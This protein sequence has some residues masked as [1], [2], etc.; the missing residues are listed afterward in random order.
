MKNL[1]D[2]GILNLSS[3]APMMVL[4]L[5]AV[6]ILV[7][8][9]IN[10][11]ISR[12]FWTMLAILGLAIN[13]FFLFGYSG[14]VRGFF[15]LVLID[16]FAFI[17][18]IIILLFSILFL[19]LTLSKE[20]FHDCSLAEFYA[21]YLFMIVGYEFMV[22][23]QNLIVILVGLETSS[24]ALYALIALHNRSRA[25]EAAIKYF[26]M[27][28]LSTGF[29][30][31]TIVLF[32][33]SSASL[34]INAISYSVKNTDPILI[35]AACIF[36]ICSIGFKLSLIPFHT[37]I[38]D[39]YEG[40]SEVMA[41]YISIVPKIAGFIVAMR[42]FESLYDSNIA[43]I[44]IS[45]YIIAVLTMTLANIMALIQNDVKRMLAF[46]SIS[47]AGFVL[48]AVVIGT[49]S[50]NIGLFLYW[51]MFSFANLGAFSVLWFTR[52]KQNIWHERFDH[53]FEKFNGL[54]KFLP[55]TSFLMALFM[56]SLAGIPPFS[57]FWGKMYLMGSAISS[58]FIFMAVIMAINSA[59][60]VYYYLRII[61]CMFLKE[62]LE[63]AEASLYK[64]NSSNAIKFIITLSAILCILAPFMV[65]FW[66]D[67]VLKFI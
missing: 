30:C 9:F 6:F 22:S 41:G 2:F 64:Q 28:A 34:D 25:I 63:N 57:V 44:Q 4:S 67:F 66:T 39:V 11:N 16:G 59:I 26:T 49:K 36:L 12:T 53:P 7:L 8:N 29:F 58:G 51:L 65:K 45:L 61:V 52:S 17:S 13:I 38:P 15:D 42:V 33:L 24:L 56:I 14:I 60:A 10:K 23:S 21:L 55:Y 19:P 18:M 37:W 1:I 46:S 48:C 5:F 3:I 31:F 20:N 50:A 35:A 43:F 32:Y 62:P 54:V 27:G 47:H 40:S